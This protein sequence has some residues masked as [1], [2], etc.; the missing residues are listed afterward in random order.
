M[1]NYNENISHISITK[2]GKRYVMWEFGSY[3]VIMWFVQTVFRQFSVAVVVVA[4]FLLLSYNWTRST[5]VFQAQYSMEYI[6]KNSVLTHNI[7]LVYSIDKAKKKSN[8][9]FT[10]I[11]H[12]YQS[13]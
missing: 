1:E 11:V 9:M 4:F 7:Y 3:C 8:I 2:N 5:S 6:S 13:V 12:V 10:F